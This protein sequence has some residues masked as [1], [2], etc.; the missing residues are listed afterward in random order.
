[1][2]GRDYEE[3]PPQVPLDADEDLS[4]LKFEIDPN[5]IY[6]LGEELVSDD[7]TAL[8][9]LIKNAYD[10]DSDDV[11]LTVE[12]DY[13]SSEFPGALG[14]IVV[15][16]SGNGMTFHQ[17]KKGWLTVSNSMK[18]GMKERG[19][20]T[21][22]GR[23]PLGD[24]G[25]GRLGAQR[26]ARFCTVETCPTVKKQPVA[27][28]GYFVHVDWEDFKR[29]D[30]LSLVPFERMQIAPRVGT[31]ITMVGL[32]NPSV[33]KSKEASA[34]FQ[35]RLSQL[36]FPF[37]AEKPFTVKG[38]I[39][40][41]RI[42][43]DELAREQLNQAKLLFSLTYRDQR[44]T[45]TGK[46]RLS[47][48]TRAK[49][50]TQEERDAYEKLVRKDNGA[51][52]FSYMMDQKASQDMALQYDGHGGWLC[53]VLM[54]IPLQELP[55]ARSL[56]GVLADPGPFQGE[57]AEFS[58]EVDELNPSVFDARSEYVDFVKRNAGIRIFR[59][60]FGVRPFGFDGD[61]W[62]NLKS[63]QT[64]GSSF[65]GLRPDNTVGYVNIG[66]RDNFRLE[67]K[68]DREGFT[69]T[70]YSANFRLLMDY[71]ISSINRT[72]TFI[73]RKY[74]EYQQSVRSSLLALDPSS[75][76]VS[77]ELLKR[78]EQAVKAQDSLRSRYEQTKTKLQETETNIAEASDNLDRTLREGGFLASPE[79]SRIFE[80]ASKVLSESQRTMGSVH[81]LMSALSERQ[82]D[83]KN[84]ENLAQ[85]VRQEQD[86]LKQ[87]LD[88]LTTLAGLGLSAE[89]ASHELYTVLD[90]LGDRTSTMTKTL[91]SSGVE[92]K[93]YLSYVRS[94]VDALRKQLGRL[95][96]SFYYVREE[97][98]VIGLSS[99]LSTSIDEYYGPRL[100]DSSIQISLD[101]RSDFQVR[102][103]RGKLN[104]VFDNL[105][106]NAQYWLSSTALETA[107]AVR[108]EVNHPWV[109]IWDTGLGVDPNL[110]HSIFEPFVSGKPKTEGRGLGLFVI[111]QLLD[112]CG[113][114]ISLLP[115]QNEFGRRYKFVIDLAEVCVP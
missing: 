67:E 12:P 66:A 100:A 19:E 16:D 55:R 9:E 72:N 89:A 85:L 48:L 71:V 15:E 90:R 99:Y 42:S 61:D 50:S 70:P 4:S 77:Q 6:Q 94:S 86:T 51:G 38:R 68:T 91:D 5:A 29:H 54:S 112:S 37:S 95:A 33:W 17:L 11:T 62:L 106:V 35:R 76:S 25:L 69:D 80:Q 46:Y 47:Y 74:T 81:H 2:D 52:F 111:R 34:D 41:A 79:V 75:K 3:Q 98:E 101:V 36:I 39:N 87:R 60:G 113:A 102:M 83:L 64:S 56:D 103:N 63:H 21:N 7:I 93:I 8:L 27:E 22:K 44:L 73:R 32:R 1:M 105:V 59:D 13:E 108:I 84:I 20:L 104:Q 26:L 115:D 110:Q 92:L 24:K 23:T 49:R 45:I 14:R 82:D 107:K 65:Y 97:K 96:P 40:G 57:L 78:T 28:W 58:L 53:S 18:K 30:A 109:T 10:A 31:R 43:L 114:T 88:Q